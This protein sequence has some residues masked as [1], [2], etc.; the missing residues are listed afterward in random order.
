MMPFEAKMRVEYIRKELE[1]S[2]KILVRYIEDMIG[3]LVRKKI[4]E[5]NEIPAPVLTSLKQR[6]EFRIEM[7]TLKEEHNI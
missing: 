2:D 5:P 7:N 3:I 1:R 6:K 4:L